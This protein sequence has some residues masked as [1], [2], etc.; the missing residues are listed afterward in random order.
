MNLDSMV[1]LMYAL[2][3]SSTEN[4]PHCV[5][6]G[7]L[8]YISHYNTKFY[9]IFLS[10][11]AYKWI[12]FLVEHEWIQIFFLNPLLC[13]VKLKSSWGLHPTTQ[14]LMDFV[15]WHSSHK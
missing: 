6:L 11:C 5:L 7:I 4:L 13:K 10:P 3:L 9:T 12:H 14:C 2:S 1:L 15:L 8:L